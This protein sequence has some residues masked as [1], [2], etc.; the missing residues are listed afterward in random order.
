MN[1]VQG[2][3]YTPGVWCENKRKKDKKKVDHNR[4]IDLKYIYGENG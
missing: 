2:R 3:G 4:L 1:Q